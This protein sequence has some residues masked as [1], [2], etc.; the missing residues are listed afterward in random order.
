MS[1]HSL[2]SDRVTDPPLGLG[3]EKGAAPRPNPAIRRLPRPLRKLRSAALTAETEPCTWAV[4][5]PSNWARAP[6][7]DKANTTFHVDPLSFLRRAA[8]ALTGRERAV[9]RDTHVT[10]VTDGG[11]N[12][13]P[14]MAEPGLLRTSGRLCPLSSP[15]SSSAMS[16]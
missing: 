10:I 9:G 12:Q 6:P 7:K 5:G 13:A 3:P 8:P 11:R 15:L 14:T 1:K 4:H 2:Q 16:T